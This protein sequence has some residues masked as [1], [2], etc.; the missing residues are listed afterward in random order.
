MATSAAKLAEIIDV[1]A[2][3]FDFEP[4]DA[5]KL[6]AADSLLPKKLMPSSPATPATPKKTSIWA[7]KQAQLLAEE[8]GI[9]LD[10]VVGSG[11]DG[12]YTI[13]D[14][15]GYMTPPPKKSKLNASP[16][17][18]KFSLENDLKLD[19][20]IGTGTDGKILLAD[21]QKWAGEESSDDE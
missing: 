6:L 9:N 7:S 18:V 13:S 1:L 15:K 16:H 2:K 17:A 19:G 4:E 21:V 11:R 8:H 3:E 12:K 5:I 20:R 14:V 10:G